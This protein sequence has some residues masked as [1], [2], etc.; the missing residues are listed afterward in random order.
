[1]KSELTEAQ[2]ILKEIAENS[3]QTLTSKIA[4]MNVDNPTNADILVRE[5]A[6]QTKTNYDTCVIMW[7]KETT[8]RIINYNKK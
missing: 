6:D 8:D 3:K 7:T 1:M 4:A 5:Y 2:Q